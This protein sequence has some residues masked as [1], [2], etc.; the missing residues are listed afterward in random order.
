MKALTITAVTS[1]IQILVSISLSA[2]VFPGGGTTHRGYSTGSM[3]DISWNLDFKATTVDVFLWDGERQQIITIAKGIPVEQRELKWSIPS[4]V[5][6]G[7]LFR[8]MVLD[9][10]NPNRKDMS[11]GFFSIV[12][13]EDTKLNDINLETEAWTAPSPSNDYVLVGWSTS[14]MKRIE[15]VDELQR[16]LFQQNITN[17]Q[18][19]ISLDVK[20]FSSGT[21]FVRLINN[22]G[23]ITI[24]PIIINR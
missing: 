21:Y 18:S 9:A 5:K 15:L 17:G 20:E 13:K 22:S 1:L 23:T 2:T 10:S 11:S 4:D 14:E 16:L 19:T 7:K 6:P 24:R 12:A 8:F 3:V